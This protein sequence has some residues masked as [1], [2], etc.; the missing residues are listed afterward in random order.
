MSAD[1]HI[2]I[3]EGI[4]ED[5]LRKFNSHTIGSKHFDLDFEDDEPDQFSEG[6]RFNRIANTP[7]I[8]VGEVSWLKA[9]LFGSSEEFIPSAVGNISELIGEEL[10]TIDDALIEKVREAMAVDNSTGYRLAETEKVL[11][12]LG[13]H[14]GKK[15]FVVSW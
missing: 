5:D 9:A 7:N 3:C 14:V 6:S 4:T 2:H 1:L 13:Q 12:F 10:P 15:V 11:E 8:W